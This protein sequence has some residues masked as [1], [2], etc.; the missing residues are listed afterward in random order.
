MTSPASVAARPP[1]RRSI[2]KGAAWVVPAV[3]VA[4]A[5]PAAAASP[6]CVSPVG[7]SVCQSTVGLLRLT[8][9]Y[10]FSVDLQNTC[11]VPLTVQA[12]VTAQTSGGTETSGQV[13]RTIA[14]DATTRITGTYDRVL[15]WNAYPTSITVTYTVGGVTASQTFSSPWD[16]TAAPTGTGRQATQGRSSERV[17]SD[18]EIRAHLEANPEL[19]EQKQVQDLLREHPEWDPRTSARAE[20]TSTPEPASAPTTRSVAP[21]QPAVDAEQP[22]GDAQET[23]G[24][25]GSASDS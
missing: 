18:Q 6:T 8:A 7:A 17:P 21:E 23:S 25:A 16:C 20:P 24:D 1:A 11:S 3:T 2:V 15:N 5:A 10:S 13:S 4:A 9:R 22:S 14:E 19:M 12:T